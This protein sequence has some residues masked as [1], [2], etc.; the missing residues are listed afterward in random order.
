MTTRVGIDI[1]GTFTDLVAMDEATGA[2][3]FSKVATVPQDL[4]AGMTDALE[5]GAVDLVATPLVLHG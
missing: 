2:I 5:R 1:G 4:V 3:R